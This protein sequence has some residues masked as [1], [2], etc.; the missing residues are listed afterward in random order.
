MTEKYEN[1]EQ[2]KTQHETPLSHTQLELHQDHRIRT[3]GSINHCGLKHF[4]CRHIFSLGPDEIL[5]TKKKDE[6]TVPLL[7]LCIR[8]KTQQSN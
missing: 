4:Y 8:V 5:I 3:V 2:A 1:K 6:K 7:N